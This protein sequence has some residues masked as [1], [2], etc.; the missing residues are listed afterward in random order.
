MLSVRRLRGSNP[1]FTSCRRAKLRISSPAETS[2]TK[3]SAISATTSPRRTN[4]P[5]SPTFDRPPSRSPVCTSARDACSDGRMPKTRPVQSEISVVK[6]STGVSIRISSIRGMFDGLSATSARSAPY[7]RSSPSAPP[8]TEST[9]LSA[10]ICTTSVPASRRGPCGSPA[11]GACGRAG[12]Q[13]VGDVRAGDEQHE[14][15]GAE[16]H[17]QR[18]PDRLPAFLRERARLQASSRAGTAS[19]NP[20]SAARPGRSCPGCPARPRR[21][22]SAARSS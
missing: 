3:A 4:A 21:S 12:E 15:H 13:Q 2:S 16:Q 7:A 14:R 20:S 19:G 11:P 18:G 9:M 22:R 1:G 10:S 6:R 5:L 8:A 17:E